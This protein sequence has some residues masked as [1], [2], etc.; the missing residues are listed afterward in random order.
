MS[1]LAPALVDRA[2]VLLF[3]LGL[4]DGMLYSPWRAED[5]G[6]LRVY[7][8]STIDRRWSTSVFSYLQLVVQQ[9]PL[10]ALLHGVQ[11]SE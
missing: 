11:A 9:F 4:D 6:A 8:R 1:S 10:L 3:L 5:L 2:P 7:L